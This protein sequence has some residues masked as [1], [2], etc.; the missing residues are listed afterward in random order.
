M[1]GTR[2]D[3]TGADGVYRFSAIPP[4]DY[5]V[6]YEL[7]GFETIIRDGA[8]CRPRVHGDRQHRAA[9]RVR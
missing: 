5:T 6:K 1:Q 2:T 3:V 7:A 4:G 8:A 9:G